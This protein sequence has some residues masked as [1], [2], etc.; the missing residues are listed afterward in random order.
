MGVGGC[1]WDR[2]V[3]WGRW[4]VGRGG[5]GVCV[6]GRGRGRNPGQPYPNCPVACAPAL[7][8]ILV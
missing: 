2:G 6:G 1:G 4:R 5:E 8:P 3:G 7:L